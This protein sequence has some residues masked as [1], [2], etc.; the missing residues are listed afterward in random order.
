MGGG[1]VIQSGNWRGA[2]DPARELEG[3]GRKLRVEIKEKYAKFMVITVFLQYTL[4]I[5]NKGHYSQHLFV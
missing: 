1:H 4:Y 2:R 3:G 5:N